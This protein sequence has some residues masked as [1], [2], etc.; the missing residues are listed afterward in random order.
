MPKAVFIIAQNKFRDEEL[1]DT[2]AELKNCEI[3]I[4]SRTKNL[5]TGMLGAKVTPTITLDDAWK[6]VQSDEYEAVIFVGGSGST[7]YFND[8]TAL[9]IARKA[10]ASNKVKVLAAICLAGIILANAGVLKG[11]KATVWDSGDLSNVKHLE[12]KGAVFADNDV[13]VDGKLVTASGPHAARFFGKE[14]DSMLK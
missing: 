8:Q 14:I 6:K 10:F 12:S 5:A 7:E 13:V 4:A 1:L 3:A 9:N 2:K 11:R